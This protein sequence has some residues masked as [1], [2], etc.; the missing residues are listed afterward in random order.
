M[1]IT[2]MT[3]NIDIAPTIAELVG[4]KPAKF[5]DG[6]SFVPFLFSSNQP[7]ADW[8]QALLIET[9]NL[10]RESPVIAYRGVRTEEFIYVEYESGE[11]EFY[12]LIADPFE[13]D[14]LA[15]SL[16]AETLSTLHAWL[17]QL[18]TCKADE[19]QRIEMAVPEIKY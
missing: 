5:V 8:R 18:K 3:A 19:C 17:E 10:D 15:G 6:R 13:M 12:D 14:N 7:S 9:G 2:Q 1:T 11:L 4:A 16:D